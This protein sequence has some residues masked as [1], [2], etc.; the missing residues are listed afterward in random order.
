MSEATLSVDLTTSPARLVVARFEGKELRVVESKDVELGPISFSA[1]TVN[2]TSPVNNG[3]NGDAPGTPTETGYDQ[4]AEKLKSA[5]RALTTPWYHSVVL[6][7]SKDYLSLC[8]ELPFSENRQINKVLGLEVQDIVPFDVNEFLLDH[9]VMGPVDG[10]LFDIHVGMVPRVEVKNVLELCKLAELDPHVLCVPVDVLSAPYVLAP[11]YFEANSAVIW[12]EHPNYLLAV[13]VNGKL[14]ATRILNSAELGDALKPETRKGILQSIR[15]GIA[16]EERRHKVTV[17]KVYLFGSALQASEVQQTVGRSVSEVTVQELVRGEQ[18]T[19]SLAT[20]GACFAEPSKATQTVNFRSGEFAYRPQFAEL[21]KGLQAL[22][23]HFVVA[24]A[25]GLITMASIYFL[26]QNEISEL[27]NALKQQI[28]SS[29]PTLQLAPGEELS[30]LGTEVVAIEQQLKDLGSLS[31][32]SALD[33]LLELSKDL[34]ATKEVNIF[35]LTIKE[36]RIS[37]EGT[38][39]SYTAIED[40]LKALKGKV[41]TYCGVEQRQNTGFGSSKDFEIIVRVC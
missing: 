37:I 32:L 19:N 6:M 28:Q 24:I 33:A 11:H 5:V 14:R 18:S 26:R 27:H 12:A 31:K 8:L 25:I 38:A 4:S 21:L 23:P 9:N 17:E 2:A 39:N 1:Q 35:K 16:S 15:L 40:M 36:D 29:I 34:P 41:G 30:R 7:P 22:L 20:L 10:S 3:N 13:S